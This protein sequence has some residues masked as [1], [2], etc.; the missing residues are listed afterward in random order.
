[1]CKLPGTG[2]GGKELN[3]FLSSPYKKSSDL[4]FDFG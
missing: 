3:T 4:V 2:T 1:M